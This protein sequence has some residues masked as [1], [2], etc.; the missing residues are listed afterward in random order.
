[1]TAPAPAPAEVTASE[2]AEATGKSRRQ[3]TSLAKRDAWPARSEP[4]RGGRRQLFDVAALPSEIQWALA[5]HQARRTAPAESPGQGEVPAAAREA[6]PTDV[7]DL[8]DWQRTCADARA[9]VLGH[10]HAIAAG[11]GLN[12]AVAAVAEA[13]RAGA[14]PTPVAAVVPRANARAGRDGDRT[15][16]PATL[17]R[18][19][20]AHKKHGWPGL[21][22]RDGTPPRAVPAWAPHLLKLYQR[23]TNPSLAK[24]VADLPAVLPD[25]VPAPSYTQAHRFVQSM[26]PAERERGRRGPNE[27]LA[28]Q[29]FKRRSTEDYAPLD[30]ATADGHTFKALVAHPIHGRPFGP[31]VCTV[32]DVVTRYVF[33]WS[34]GLAESRW[35]VMDALRHGVEQLGVCA[36]LFTDNGSGF[37]NQTLD[38]SEVQGLMARCGIKHT[39]STPGR[40]QSRGKIER[41]QGSLWKRAARDLVTYRGHDMDPE[42]RK[43]VDKV[44]KRDVKKNGGSRHLMTWKDFM[45][46]AHAAVG[47]Y[48]H[49]PHRSLPKTYDAETGARRHMSPAEALDAWRQKGWQPETLPPEIVEDLFRP[50]EIRTVQRG[51]ISLPWGRYYADKLVQWHRQK[52]RVGYDIHDGSRV[53]VREQET[54]RLIC[55]AARD[56]NVVPEQPA[57]MVEHALRQRASRRVALIDQ[58]RAEA[59]SELGPAM[60]ET[61]PDGSPDLPL[62][63]SIPNGIPNGR[64][65][66]AHQAPPRQRGPSPAAES[67]PLPTADDEDDDLWDRLGQVTAA[68]M[69][70][71]K[72]QP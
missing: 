19:H 40:A 9:V 58:H 48:N 39:T 7:A 61:E 70:E 17:K 6:V 49:R 45:S 53:W 64:V 67:A 55:V 4:V 51:E 26:P 47:D 25:G 56:G 59:E 37:V 10:L 1:M 13:A 18:W 11:C 30:V 15:L 50:Y 46:W 65:S 12:K 14:L 62:I 44:L 60:L 36:L 8:A 20:S 35:V 27:L 24:V 72:P 71:R 29:G 31:E 69:A 2:I 38:D 41:L 23:P 5:A 66:A 57:S 28:L 52:V 68:H 34:V 32:M 16:S 43:R 63:T 33:G 42:A 54:G 22:P 3:V 21:V